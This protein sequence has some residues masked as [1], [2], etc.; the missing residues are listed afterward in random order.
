[1]HGLVWLTLAW[2]KVKKALVRWS[3][4]DGACALRRIDVMKLSDKNKA[5]LPSFNTK[6]ARKASRL[7]GQ[8]VPLI[9]Q[10]TV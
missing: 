4:K 2:K 1:M 5:Y 10:L 8:A 9:R 7:H 6:K 3:E